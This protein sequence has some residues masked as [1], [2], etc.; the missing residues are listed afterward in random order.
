MSSN[1]KGKA[2]SQKSMGEKRQFGRSGNTQ[3]IFGQKWTKGSNSRYY[4][5]GDFGEANGGSL[6][7]SPTNILFTSLTCGLASLNNFIKSGS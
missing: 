1:N 6:S 5:E 2:A 4:L 7:R 3:L